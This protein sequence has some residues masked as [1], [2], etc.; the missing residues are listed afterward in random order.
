MVEA[1]TDPSVRWEPNNISIAYNNYTDRMKMELPEYNDPASSGVVYT[2]VDAASFVHKYLPIVSNTRGGLVWTPASGKSFVIT[3]LIIN[4]ATAGTINLYDNVNTQATQV[5]QLT[6]P[7]TATMNHPFKKPYPS[8]APDN[9]LKYDSYGA[10]SGYMT[11][12]GFEI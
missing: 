5:V 8:S 2:S 6:M 1:L 9:V 3:D 4:T 10:C 7:A 11:V 12:N